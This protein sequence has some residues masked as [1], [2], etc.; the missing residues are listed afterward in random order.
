M[1]APCSASSFQYDSKQDAD[2]PV[3]NQSHSYGLGT[4]IQPKL[5]EV[6]LAALYLACYMLVGMWPLVIKQ[7][8]MLF[9]IV[10][11]CR[12][13]T[14]LDDVREENNKI[15]N[16]RVRFT[17]EAVLDIGNCNEHHIVPVS[18]GHTH[19]D[20]ALHLSH[21]EHC[22]IHEVL[23]TMYAESYPIGGVVNRDQIIGFNEF[24]ENERTNL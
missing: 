19:T 6:G 4:C 17:Q 7:L 14:T 1:S 24:D 9:V 11:L 15:F 8:D 16:S 2:S 3:G 12:N 10:W 13:R 5:L 23:T 20:N 21:E 18:V 22:L